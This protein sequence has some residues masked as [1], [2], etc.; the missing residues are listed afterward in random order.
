MSLLAKQ[1]TQGEF[2]PKPVYLEIFAYQCRKITSGGFE[3]LLTD[4]ITMICTVSGVEYYKPECECRTK[5][6]VFNHL[7][8]I[9][10][11]PRK[12]AHCQS[13]SL[14]HC[15]LTMS[16]HLLRTRSVNAWPI[17][18]L[19]WSNEMSDL[20]MPVE[21]VFITHRCSTH[22]KGT[23]CFRCCT[24]WEHP[25]FQLSGTAA[26]RNNALGSYPDLDR[27]CHGIRFEE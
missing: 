22:R 4:L 5:I 24:T 27:N 13:G 6:I 26:E 19:C 12:W 2:V 10:F 3:L 15:V 8:V 25:C 1:V 20:S 18:S 7:C 9:W 21:Y 14:A 17:G 16:S 23:C 11:L